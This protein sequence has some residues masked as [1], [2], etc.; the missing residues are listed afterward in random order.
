MR[1]IGRVAAA[2]RN[3]TDC[4]KLKFTATRFRT[5]MCMFTHVAGRPVCRWSHRLAIDKDLSLLGL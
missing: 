5:Y 2:L 4:V 1:D 3:V